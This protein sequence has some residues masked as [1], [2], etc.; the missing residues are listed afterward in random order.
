M[1]MW[2]YICLVVGAVIGWV[3]CAICTVAKCDD[4]RAG[5]LDN[6]RN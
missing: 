3:L 6:G 2:H 4:C 5:R 1:I